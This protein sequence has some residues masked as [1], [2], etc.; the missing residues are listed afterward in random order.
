[1][2]RGHFVED[3][4]TVDFVGDE[5]EIV[6]YTEIRDSQD[7]GF[8]KH[9]AKRVLRIAE[10]E[11][12]GFGRNCRLHALPI[13]GPCTVNLDVVDGDQ[14]RVRIVMH[15]D[16]GWIDRGAGHQRIACFAKCATSKRE[17][18]DESAE[19]DDVFDGYLRLAALLEVLNNRIV[20]ALMRLRIAENSVI[21]PAVQGIENAWRRGKIH[22]SHPEGIEF[23]SAI[24]LDA[25]GALAGDVAVE[26]EMHGQRFWWR[27]GKD[28]SPVVEKCVGRFARMQAM[29]EVLSTLPESPR[30]SDSSVNR[31]RW[32]GYVCPDCRLVFR[33]SMDHD[34]KGAV[35]PACS[36]MLRIPGP[37]EKLPPL[38]MPSPC[39]SNRP[40]SSNP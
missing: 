18:G 21:N 36:R 34:G 11:D 1:M 33:L 16:E 3:E 38:V 27:I 35:C 31:R 5:H 30:V 26:I 17:G 7:V 9:A 10:Q 15:A 25:A 13:E 4:I 19:V 2:R 37:G 14:F 23:G 8:G 20:Q 6:A 22:V 24:I 28:S 29:L 39:G 40:G 32:S 12:L